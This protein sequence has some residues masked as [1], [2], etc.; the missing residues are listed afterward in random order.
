MRIRH[1]SGA[2][3]TLMVAPALTVLPVAQPFATPN[4]TPVPTS[5]RRVDL[6]DPGAPQAG[7]ADK[8][9]AV[10]L[11]LARDQMRGARSAGS[12]TAGPG[13]PLPAGP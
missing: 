1:L 5:E 3:A 9:G 10:D 11:K 12:S 13:A 8:T 4:P 2:V 7:D 6:L